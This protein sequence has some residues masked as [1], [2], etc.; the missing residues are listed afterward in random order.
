M[1]S[2]Y[3]GRLFLILMLTACSGPGYYMQAVSGQW[4][5]MHGRQDIQT[6]IK[7]PST[8]PELSDQLQSAASIKEFAQ[9]TLELPGAQSYTSFVEIDGTA[10]VW[11]V[12]ATPEF[13]LQPKKWCFPVAGCVPYRG[14][15]DR[16]KALQSAA[17]LERK[18][19]DVSV[20]PATAYSSLGWFEDPLLSTML[21]G[22]DIRLAAYL[23]HELAHQRLYL[24]GDSAFNEG[25]ASFVEENGVTNWL[26][27]QN[28][29]DE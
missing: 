11:N 6:L 19:M 23:F 14:Y 2:R 1:V 29:Q 9:K 20:S 13:S 17:R 27:S 28:R 16:Q 8:S 5:L 15:F 24:K 10:V 7:D 22:S 26:Q 3:S 4:K 18:G 21:T 12:V 25:Y